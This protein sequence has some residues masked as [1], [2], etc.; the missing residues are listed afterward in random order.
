MSHNKNHIIKAHSHINKKKIIRQMSEVL[1]I[2]SGKLKVF[3]YDKKKNKKKNNYFEKKRYDT[4]DK[5][6]SWI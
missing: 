6:C 3:F 2:F 4:F 1:I 5:R